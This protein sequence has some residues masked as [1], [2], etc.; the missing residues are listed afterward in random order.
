MSLD[1]SNSASDERLEFLKIQLKKTLLIMLTDENEPHPFDLLETKIIRALA[2]ND[3]VE[4]E[5]MYAQLT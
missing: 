2:T 1:I 4:L 3:L 5:K